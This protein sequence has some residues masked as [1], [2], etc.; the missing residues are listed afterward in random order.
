VRIGNSTPRAAVTAV[1]PLRDSDHAHRE[2]FVLDCPQATFFDSIGWRE[3]YGELPHLRPHY[4]IA[5][6]GER[7]ERIIRVLPVDRRAAI[8][9]F[10]LREIDPAQL[11][12]PRRG[13]ETRFRHYVNLDKTGTCLGRLLRDFRWAPVDDVPEVAA[14]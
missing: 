6:R 2:R 5:E 13:L 9:Y 7:G 4:L 11:R 10:H 8:F 1:R 12:I 14:A 3:I